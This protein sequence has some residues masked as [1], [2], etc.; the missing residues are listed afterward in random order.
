MKLPIG[1]ALTRENRSCLVFIRKHIPSPTMRGRGQGEGAGKPAAYTLSPIL[2]L[3]GRGSFLMG[4][5]WVPAQ[6]GRITHQNSL[7]NFVLKCRIV[8]SVEGSEIRPESIETRVLNRI[9]RKRGDVFLQ[10]D[11]KD[12]G[13]YNQVGHVLRGLV[14]KGRLLKV[15]HGLYT[16]ALKLA[17]IKLFCVSRALEELAPITKWVLV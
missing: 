15:S 8:T 9:E 12:L 11:F 1:P 3:E 10:S 7:L 4:T 17:R 16:R 13:G 2:S 5:T 14:R 6:V